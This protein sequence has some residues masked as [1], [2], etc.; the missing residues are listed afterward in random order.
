MYFTAAVDEQHH[1]WRQRFPDGQ[2]QQLTFGTDEE[3]GIAVAPDGSI[4]TSIGAR[5][6]ELWIHDGQGDRPVSSEGAIV[7]HIASVTRPSFSRDGRY[8]YYLRRASS[9]GGPQLWR[10]DLASGHTEAVLPGIEV[11]EYDLSE[12]GRVVFSVQ[13][14][15]TSQLWVSPLDRGAPPRQIAASGE[16]APFFGLGNTVLFRFTKGNTSFVGRMNA[17]GSGRTQAMPHPIGNVQNISPDRRWL[18][19]IAPIVGGSRSAATVAFSMAGGAPRPI[20]EGTCPCAWSPDGTILYVELERRSRVSAGKMVGL[21]V[22]RETGL[23][24]LPETG[25]RSVPQA[26]AI[27]GSRLIERSD[28]VPGIDPGTYAYLKTAVHRNLFRLRLP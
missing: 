10:T 17:D 12:D 20:C 11:M 16:T 27:P 14:A 9:G 26:L 3:D 7:S 28:I 4:V 25:I 15:G 13:P 6:S 21:P 18:V 24:A 5:Q 22:L 2:P 8:L 19:A 23:P 1:L